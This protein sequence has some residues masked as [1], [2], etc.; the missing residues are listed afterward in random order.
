MLSLESVEAVLPVLGLQLL[1]FL[2]LLEMLWAYI[3]YLFQLFLQAL[4]LLCF[5]MF[6][7]PDVAVRWNCHV[8]HNYILCF[9]LTISISGWLPA[10]ETQSLTGPFSPVVP[11]H[12]W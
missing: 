11:N 1:M 3:P 6:V 10:A 5:L 9:L 4:V 7:L 2:L 8:Y 12:L